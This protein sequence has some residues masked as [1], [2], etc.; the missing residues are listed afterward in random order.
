MCF[1][2]VLVEADVV[3]QSAIQKNLQQ[4]GFSTIECLHTLEE[5]L[6]L[7]FSDIEL[8]VLSTEDALD[9]VVR[10]IRVIKSSNPLIGIVVINRQF[11]KKEIMILYDEGIDLF[12]R[13]PFDLD[14]F[15][16]KV[17]SLRNRI[18]TSYCR[19]YIG[20]VVIDIS[21][22]SMGRKSELVFLNPSEMKIMLKLIDSRNNQLLTKADINR[23]LYHNDYDL[24]ATGAKVYIYRLRE[25]L[26]RVGTECVMIKN[27]YGN[28]YYLNVI[29]N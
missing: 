25:K 6:P 18:E 5:L 23:L 14:V 15:T 9:K 2:V 1:T 21:Q 17:K 13:K 8:L 11:T 20:D 24:T 27:N 3:V 19:K 10:Y 26:R 4:I 28:G 16:L 12:S 29:E 22:S 7:D